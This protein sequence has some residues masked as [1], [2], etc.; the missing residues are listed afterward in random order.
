MTGLSIP[1]KK[2]KNFCS[3]YTNL[4]SFDGAIHPKSDSG[5]LNKKAFL[6]NNNTMFVWLIFFTNG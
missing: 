6:Y 4:S 3:G 1:G 5:I 2:E